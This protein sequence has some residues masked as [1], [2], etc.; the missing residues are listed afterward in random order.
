MERDKGTGGIRAM[1]A[2]VIIGTFLSGALSGAGMYHWLL[3]YRSH[4]LHHPG[5]P[6]FAELGLSAEQEAKAKAI[7]DAHRPELENILHDTFPKVR[8][9]HE[10]I[11]GELRALLNADQRKRFDQWKVDHPDHHGPGG[12]GGP[13][14]G[15][16][17]FAPP[18]HR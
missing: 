1:T 14:F 15:P 11:D 2:L 10:R 8:A 13:H 4:P 9:V 17:G 7:M 16:P 6:P 18:D 3:P 12:H 5:G